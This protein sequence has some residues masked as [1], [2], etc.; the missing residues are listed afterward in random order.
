[1]TTTLDRRGRSPYKRRRAALWAAHTDGDTCPRCLG[2]MYRAQGLQADHVETMAMVDPK[3][4][5]DSLSH[6]VCNT[7]HGQ[8]V[9]AATRKLD[10]RFPDPEQREVE[11]L[12]IVAEVT[13]RVHAE[14]RAH[15]APRTTRTSRTW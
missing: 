10:E 13:A 1:M 5:P 11:K 3:A 4:L 12:R 2:P 9:G 14:L 15:R 7:R 6:M 8:A